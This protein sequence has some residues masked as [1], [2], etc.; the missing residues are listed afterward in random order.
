MTDITIARL[1][2]SGSEGPVV[3]PDLLLRPLA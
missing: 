1:A 3:V 2:E